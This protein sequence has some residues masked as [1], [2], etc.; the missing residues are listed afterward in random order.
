MI[1]FVMGT[2]TLVVFGLLGFFL[3]LF[4]E[5]WQKRDYRLLCLLAGYNFFLLFGGYIYTQLF[6]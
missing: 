1:L 6:L 3:L 4:W 5:A 2:I